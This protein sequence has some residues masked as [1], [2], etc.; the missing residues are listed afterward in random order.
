M[1][2][3]NSLD[4]LWHSINGE[5]TDSAYCLVREDV[6]SWFK[7]AFLEG[8]LSQPTTLKKTATY[9]V[10]LM[11]APFLGPTS[12]PGLDVANVEAGQ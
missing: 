10:H 6:G 1:N 11:L 2:L 5:R 12:P 9:Y 3:G 4:G 7:H 8:L